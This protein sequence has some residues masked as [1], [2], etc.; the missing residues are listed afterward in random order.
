MAKKLST[1]MQTR[2]E[3]MLHESG[4][5]RPIQVKCYSYKLSQARETALLGALG[6][7][8]KPEAGDDDK[9]ACGAE[10]A[11]THR[12]R[13]WVEVVSKRADEGEADRR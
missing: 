6:M 1:R 13:E 2:L 10:D 11:R 4:R 7:Q 5:Y 9:Q 3:A 12:C 8:C